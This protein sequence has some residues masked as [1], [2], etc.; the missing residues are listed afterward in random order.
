MPR[1]LVALVVVLAGAA[2]AADPLAKPGEWPL[3]RRDRRLSGHQPMP[4]AIRKPQVAWRHDLRGWE[5]L[6]AVR[7]GRG[8][9]TLALNRREP[10]DPGYWGNHRS[11][12]GLGTPRYDL[13]GDGKTTAIGP[14]YNAKIGTL[15]PGVKG[16]QRVEIVEGRLPFG[17]QTHKGWVYCQA[18]DRG[19]D[20]P[21]LVWKAPAVQ[22]THRPYV[23]LADVDAD[24]DLDVVHSDWGQLSAHDGQTGKLLA[25]VHWLDRRHRGLFIAQNIDDDPFPEFVVLGTFHMNVSVVDN[26]GKR[27]RVLWSRDIE[28]QIEVQ[29]RIVRAPRHCLG[30]LDGDGRVELAYNLIDLTKDAKWHVV[31]HDATSGQVVAD[32]AGRY[33]DSLADLDGDGR[34]ELFLSQSDGLQLPA[35]RNLHVASLKGGGLVERWRGRG[36]LHQR[37]DGRVPVHVTD[38]LP[39]HD[40]VCGDLDGDGRPEWLV[41]TRDGEAERLE[42]LGLDGKG[43]VGQRA[44]LSWPR[45]VSCEV[46]AVADADGDGRSEMLLRCRGS[47]GEPVLRSDGCGLELLSWSLPSGRELVGPP[48]VADLE[49]EGRPT[50]V[51]PAAWDRVIALRAPANGQG[52]GEL[53]RLPGRGMTLIY[54]HGHGGVAACD[55]DR[56]GRKEVIFA[57]GGP[58]T[59]GACIQAVDARG[60]A[61]WRHEFPRI[62]WA[63][64]RGWG[65]GA[66]RTWSVGRF[67]RGK[68]PDVTV[69]AHLNCMHSGTSYLLDGRSGERVWERICLKGREK[70]MGGGH[71]SI[72]DTDGDGLDEIAGGYCNFL[73]TLDGP[74]GS[75]RSVTH[76][77]SLFHPVMKGSWVN[78]TTPL[79]VDADGDGTLEMLVGRHR[80]M[81]ALLDGTARKIRWWYPHRSG[82]HSM[83][84]LADVDGDGK[85]EVGVVGAADQG[86]WLWC[87]GLATGKVEW[88]MAVP[89]SSATDFASGDVDGD[90]LADFLFAID[91]VLFAVGG[92]GGKPRLIWKLDLSASCGPPILADADGDGR[93]EVLLV[94]ADGLLRCIDGP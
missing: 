42:A 60:K 71:V 89:S 39:F 45:G 58:H 55:L 70:E 14:R 75:V 63:P 83:P 9:S 64:T 32:V 65:P 51:V 48:I 50:V 20:R 36:R 80:S 7:P 29:D 67:R 74:N 27:L 92:R 78:S 34:R 57:T 46:L 6:V 24:G 47:A 56:D 10:K 53:W 41:S 44:S 1:R 31:I 30:D 16:L 15:L 61:E 81:V 3:W 85:L 33:L 59:G 73:F 79:L 52:P 54:E 37:F 66:M 69:S 93:S 2:S 94:G 84:G 28:P 4:G 8:P 91:R 26:D 25:K 88:R 35:H 49:G 87:L 38:Q 76:S 77:A 13:D 5:A 43:K 19:E 62:Q 21:R 68:P 82:G 40:A 22:K 12:W 86:G 90:G 23:A 72:A 17:E 18:Y 11:T